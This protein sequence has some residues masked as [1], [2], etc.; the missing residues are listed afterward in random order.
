MIQ[1]RAKLDLSEVDRKLAAM[2]AS[3]RSLGPAWREVSKSM[4][5][6]QREHARDQEGPDSKWA[7]RSPKT[8]AKLRR[9]GKRLSRRPL[10]KLVQA[11]TYKVTKLGVTATSRVSWSGIHQYGGRAARG[12]VIPARPF[13]WLSEQLLAKAANILGAKILRAFED[14]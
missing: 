8:L 3:S 1:L 6:D 9:G 4:R 12:S 13:L 11:V 7:A 5:L 14:G 2:R 10:G